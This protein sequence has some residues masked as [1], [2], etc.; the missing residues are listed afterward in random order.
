[1]IR[2]DISSPSQELEI[3]S[4]C[5][6][7]PDQI[8]D[9]NPRDLVILQLKGVSWTLDFTVESK[10]LFILLQDDTMPNFKLLT[11]EEIEMT[12]FKSI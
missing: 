6:N 8:F 5:L 11:D 12:H 2:S 4:L 1:V 10:N 9:N 3:Q 7:Y